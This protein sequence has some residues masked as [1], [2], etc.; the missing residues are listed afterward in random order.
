MPVIAGLLHC[1]M[2][3]KV[4]LTFNTWSIWQDLTP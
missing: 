3:P 2:R 4:T 1:R